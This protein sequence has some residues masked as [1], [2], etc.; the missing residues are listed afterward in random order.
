MKAEDLLKICR[1]AKVNHI[2]SALDPNIMLF[3]E[4]LVFMVIGHIVM[5]NGGDTD[6]DDFLMNCAISSLS[7]F[8][9]WQFVR[10]FHEMLEFLG[11]QQGITTLGGFDE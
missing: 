7:N 6:Y 5:L 4:F 8:C 2:F 9:Y 3:D 10:S 11:R 1:E